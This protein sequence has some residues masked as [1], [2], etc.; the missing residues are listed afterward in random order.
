MNHK[1]IGITG[2]ARAG[3]DTVANYLIHTH[4]HY[5]KM[6]FSEPIKKMLSAGLGISHDQLY[7][8]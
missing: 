6:S 3:K 7:G 8:N 2:A 4:P 1:V 5:V